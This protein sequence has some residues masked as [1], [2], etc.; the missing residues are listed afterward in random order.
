M[1]SS[2]P[3]IPATDLPSLRA[4]AAVAEHSAAGLLLADAQGRSRWCNAAFARL[5]GAEPASLLLQP[6]AGWLPGAD[7]CLID[8]LADALRG[9][10]VPAPLELS[11]ALPGGP[12]RW[13]Q[14]DAQ[15]IEGGWVLTLQE[16]T[17]EVRER[18]ERHRLSEQLD[19]AQEFGRL[20]VWER[21]VRS[22]R[23]RWDR[24]VHRFWGLP[25]DAPTPGFDEALARTHPGD[26]TREIVLSSYLR[27]GTYSHRYRV[28][29]PDGSVRLLHAQWE[30]KNGADGR[31]QRAIGTVMDDTEVFQLARAANEVHEQLDM[32]VDLARIGVWRH[33]LATDRLHYS[34][35]AWEI[36]GLSP[37]P[38]GLSLHEARELIHPEDLPAVF[39]SAERALHTD[40]PTDLQARYRRADGSWRHLLMRRAVQRDV[41]GEPVAFLGVA[42]DITDQVEELRRSSALSQR[43]AAAARAARLG[44]WSVQVSTGRMLWNEQ[45]HEFF[46]LPAGQ[47]PSDFRAWI[48]Q[49]VH[50]DDRD[51]I[52]ERSLAWVRDAGSEQHVEFHYRAVLPDGQ[53]RWLVNRSD[54]DLGRDGDWVFGV[55]LD[56]TEQQAALLALRS[57]HE[58]SVLAA[59][60]VGMGAWEQDLRSGIDHWDEQM[61]LLRGLTPRATPLTAQERLALVHPDDRAKV[62]RRYDAALAAGKPVSYEFRVRLPDGS[63]RWL[64]SR[65]TTLF[66]EHG[67]AVR[68]IGVNWDVTD[69][70][71]AEAARQEKRIAQRESEAKSRFMARM[72][73]ELRT[74][75]NAVLGFTQLLLA[76]SDRID[77]A[78]LRLRLGHI[79]A[80]GQHLL[81]LINDVLEL[82]SLDSGELSLQLQPVTLAQLVQGTLPLIER[83]AQEYQVRLRVGELPGVALADPTRLRQ[84]L[85]NLLSNGIKYNRP[86]GEV[87]VQSRCEDRSEGGGDLGDGRTVVLQVSDTGRGMTPQ[88]LRHVF[89]PFNRLGLEREGIEGTGI[90]LAIVKAIVQRMQ[91]R[92]TVLSES[93][94]GSRFEVR[95]P[96]A[97]EDGVPPDAVSPAGPD[98]AL[99]SGLDTGPGG[100]SSFAG[101]VAVPSAPPAPS[102]PPPSR[103][104]RRGRLLYIEDNPVNALIVRELVALRP[105][106]TLDVA[107]D[108]LTGVAL[109]LQQQPELIL[110]DMQLPDIDGLAVLRRLRED[111][112]TAAVPCIALSANAMPQDIEAALQ[113]GFADYWTKPLDMKAFMSAIDALF[114]KE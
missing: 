48:A 20:G 82:S 24:H 61:F 73:H 66:D 72:S 68:R 104:G 85:L 31:P 114:P 65:S 25:A 56:V 35:R 21:D 78:A 81:S 26:R 94:V 33:D 71:N 110:V 96:C 90:G 3:V 103:A 74:P 6:P 29:Q 87:H 101:L 34:A 32:A 63:W 108:G 12:A 27:A 15:H 8:A 47:A 80:A 91:G 92:V 109:A 107:A 14:L 1:P 95:L 88:Q 50:A 11:L 45:M 77:P 62:T 112:R 40:R 52:L 37:R 39:S 16:R 79:R 43:M 30:V 5:L 67:A 38:Q 86:G 2:G 102:L 57:A 51:R 83:M 13:L 75:L 64:A 98:T 113:A 70:R 23:G 100:T 46:G 36:L 10:V 22:L 58:R 59:R 69:S 9:P 55:T 17:A 93:G 97:A 49:C 53:L 54:T 42:L 84:V 41:H 18:H 44:L 7:P 76:E 105:E 19:M 106:L 60:G 89:E 99:D 4:L 28:L 111:P